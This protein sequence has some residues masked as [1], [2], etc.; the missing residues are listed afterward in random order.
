[1]TLNRVAKDKAKS[2]NPML[3]KSASWLPQ[4]AVHRVRWNDANGLSN[5]GWYAAGTASGLGRVEWVEGRFR[6]G[7]VPKVAEQ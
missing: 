6:R 2:S 5:A 1:M 4:V 7:Q 3:M